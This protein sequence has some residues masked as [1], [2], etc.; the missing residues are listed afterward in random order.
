MAGKA[1]EGE[2]RRA[3]RPVRQ[4]G[5][6]VLPEALLLTALSVVGP[7]E[8][9]FKRRR[10]PPGSGRGFG[11][12][13]GKRWPRRWPPCIGRKPSDAVGLAHRG[14][15]FGPRYAGDRR[16]RTARQARGRKVQRKGFQPQPLNEEDLY[17]PRQR[18]RLAEQVP[19]AR[20]SR[21][22]GPRGQ[23][24]ARPPLPVQ[25]TFALLL[26]PKGLRWGGSSEFAGG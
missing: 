16:V 17:P 7:F 21:W 2:F 25:P 22:A 26:P 14:T 20:E 23:L 10:R 18:W 8:A 6:C 24:L 1:D 15:S 9:I 11:H 12:R 19:P 13:L 5:L 3:P 4:N